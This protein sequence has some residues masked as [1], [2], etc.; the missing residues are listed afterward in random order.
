[1]ISLAW[2]AEVAL[3]LLGTQGESLSFE[4]K[5][6]VPFIC[7]TILNPVRPS[8]ER[9][10]GHLAKGIELFETEM[11]DYGKSEDKSPFISHYTSL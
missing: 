11:T 5:L 2:E 8:S 4:L 7:N 1:M 3:S 10:V 9:L 6:Y